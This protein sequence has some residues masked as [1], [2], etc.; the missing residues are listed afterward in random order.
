MKKEVLLL[1]V[2]V[3]SINFF[4]VGV[5]AQ[6]SNVSNVSSGKNV[7]LEVSGGITPDSS[8]YFI[9]EFFDQFGD[10]LKIREEKIAEIKTMIKEGKIDKAKNAL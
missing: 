1:L 8:F 7:K 3:F 5:Y 10:K 2:F 4:M 6:N 9:D